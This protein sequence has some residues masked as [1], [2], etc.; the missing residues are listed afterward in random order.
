M[1]NKSLQPKVS[2]VIPAFNEEKFLPATLNSLLNQDS[3]DFEV[4]VVDNNSSD[5]TAEIARQFGAKVIFEP[6]QG[7]G[8]ARQAGFQAAHA[9]IIASTDADTVVPP[10]WISRIIQEFDN[11]P[12]LV[13]FGGPCYLYSGPLFARLMSRW[14]CCAYRLLDKIMSGG[15]TMMGSNFAV[16]KETFLK[17]NGFNVNLTMGEDVDF[18]LRA[19]KIGQVKF[20]KKFR[21]ETSGRRFRHGLFWGLLIY[22]PNWFARVIFNKYKFTKLPPVRKETS[23]LQKY[24]ILPLSLALTCFLIIFYN[25]NAFINQ[26]RA[27]EINP[28]KINIGHVLT[29]LKHSGS[30]INKSFHQD[31]KKGFKKIKKIPYGKKVS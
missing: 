19:Q 28:N 11:N 18:S 25:H 12:Q 26:V 13:I 3:D 5:R 29:Y 21:V 10:N 27:K 7:V 14:L 9:S 2:V 23:L 6:R 17:I 24:K 4:I 31:L 15:W 20:D 1:L 22:I 30:K 16:K 8:F